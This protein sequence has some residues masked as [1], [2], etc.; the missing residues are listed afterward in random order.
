MTKIGFDNLLISTFINIIKILALKNIILSY[1][2]KQ[3]L[4]L[5]FLL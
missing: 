4:Q 5:Y 3:N 2:L 1:N